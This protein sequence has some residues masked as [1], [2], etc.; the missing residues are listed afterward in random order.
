MVRCRSGTRVALL[1]RGV[2]EAMRSCI[3]RADD[4]QLA[5]KKHTHGHLATSRLRAVQRLSPTCWPNLTASDPAL[6]PAP[7]TIAAPAATGDSPVSVLGLFRCGT[8]S[9]GRLH[10]SGEQ[11]HLVQHHSRHLP[12]RALD[13]AAH[14]QP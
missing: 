12:A 8:G 4:M 1:S 10:R 5:A 6:M 14:L 9:D 11:H 7:T 2:V 13:T 3:T